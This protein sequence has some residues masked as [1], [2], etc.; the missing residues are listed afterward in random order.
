M[1]IFNTVRN[2]HII[3]VLD[4]TFFNPFYEYEFMFFLQSR[5]EGSS[6]TAI[7]TVLSFVCVHKRERARA[8]EKG[9]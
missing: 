8:R 3:L 9:A 6:L 2:W 7:D 4:H 1:G 5:G